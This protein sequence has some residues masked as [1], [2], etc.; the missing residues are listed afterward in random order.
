MYVHMFV[1]LPKTFD[2]GDRFSQDQ[3]PSNARLFEQQ[4]WKK[5]AKNINSFT[6]NWALFL[7]GGV[8]F[9]F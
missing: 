6:L 9:F 4:I 5:L 7:Q 1:Y 3:Y 2:R 8:D